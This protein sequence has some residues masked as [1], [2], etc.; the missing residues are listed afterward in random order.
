LVVGSS[1]TRGAQIPSVAI[2]A[3]RG[4]H[5]VHVFGRSQCVAVESAG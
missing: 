2:G 5:A 1:P 4:T 3:L